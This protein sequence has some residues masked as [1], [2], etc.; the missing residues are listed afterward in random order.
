MSENGNGH[1]PLDDIFGS[2]SD[3]IRVAIMHSRTGEPTGVV[4]VFKPIAPNVKSSYDRIIQ[5]GLGSKQ[6]KYDEGDKYVFPKIIQAI[7]GLTAEHCDGLEPIVYCQQ[8]PKGQQLLKILMNGYWSL[9]LPSTEED[10][11][12][13]SQP[14]P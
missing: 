9:V 10:A 3:L 2:E 8:K 14:Q 4:G 12:K 5:K 6:P 1:N 13:K 11:S 7:E